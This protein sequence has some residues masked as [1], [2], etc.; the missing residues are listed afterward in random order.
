MYYLYEKYYKHITVQYYIADCCQ[1]GAQANFLDLRTNWIYKHVLGMEGFPC[2][3][4][5]EESTC[6]EGDLGLIPGIG[7]SLGEGKG[8]LSSI[9][10]WRIPWTV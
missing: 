3:S 9:L 10:A 6:N 7:R 2:G 1:L 4:A 8:Y 5:G